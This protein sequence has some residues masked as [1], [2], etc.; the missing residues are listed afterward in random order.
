MA[1]S[2]SKTIKVLCTIRDTNITQL[3]NLLGLSRENIHAQ[4][5][6]DNFK[7]SDIEKM[8][9]SLNYD[10]KLIFVDRD[11]EKEIEADYNKE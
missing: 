10:V 1:I 11:T 6:R 9:D 3:G 4:I 5:K 7:M 8:A 2:I